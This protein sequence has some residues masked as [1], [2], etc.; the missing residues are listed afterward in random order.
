MGF[1]G[2]MVRS[3]L[4]GRREPAPEPP[5]L[6]AREIANQMTAVA[7]TA[8]ELGNTNKKRGRNALIIE[9][10]KDKKA[11]GTSALNI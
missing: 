3:L 5:K 2:N 6:T 9:R 10:D 8:P 4:G 11:G 1:I 7:P